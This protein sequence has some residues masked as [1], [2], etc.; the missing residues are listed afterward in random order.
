MAHVDSMN[1]F[2]QGQKIM[3]GFKFE[4]LMIENIILHNVYPRTSDKQLV[5]PKL[6]TNLIKLP[7]KAL[8]ALQLRITKALGNRSH[9]IEMSIEQIDD[10]SFFQ[11]AAAMLHANEEQFIELSKKLAKDLNVAQFSTNAP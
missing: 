7:Q 5:E 9:G 1:T 10:D 6:S 4:G 3:S 8:G 2:I 11:N